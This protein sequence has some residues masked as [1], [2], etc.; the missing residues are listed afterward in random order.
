MGVQGEFL[1]DF[2]GEGGWFPRSILGQTLVVV[3]MAILT[4][5]LQAHAVTHVLAHVVIH[6]LARVLTHVLVLPYSASHFYPHFASTCSNTRAS[7]CSNTRASTCYY[8]RARLLFKNMRPGPVTPR[9]ASGKTERAG[10][11]DTKVLEL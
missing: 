7:T 3:Y 6:V 10:E 8:A 4:H 2:K 1:S 5:I 11:E 9:G